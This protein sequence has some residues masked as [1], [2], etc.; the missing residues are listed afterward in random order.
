MKEGVVKTGYPEDRV[1]VIPNYCDQD[2]FNADVEEAQKLRYQYD[3]LQDRTLVIYA[4]TI[5]FVKS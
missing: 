1:M 2:L 3:W 4:G 5:G